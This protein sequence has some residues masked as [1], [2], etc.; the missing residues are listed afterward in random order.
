MYEKG[1]IMKD[2]EVLVQYLSCND[3]LFTY[4]ETHSEKFSAFVRHLQDAK[5]AEDDDDFSRKLNAIMTQFIKGLR[6]KA[7]FLKKE[8][9]NFFLNILMA[10]IW[11]QLCHLRNIMHFRPFLTEEKVTEVEH[12]TQWSR[13]S[14]LSVEELA[15]L[16]DLL[17]MGK[18]ML[19]TGETQLHLLTKEVM[20]EFDSI[21]D[22]AYGYALESA[23]I[24]HEQEQEPSWF[25]IYCN[26]VVLKIDVVMKCLARA[27]TVI[28]YTSLCM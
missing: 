10:I 24:P 23:S 20:K 3:H 18:T 27:G 6:A 13:P 5:D 9:R 14:L 11:T 12:L 25:K 4:M 21:Y 1:V 26:S 28:A 15:R 16:H 17:K 8:M 19:A 2:G 7:L 22:K